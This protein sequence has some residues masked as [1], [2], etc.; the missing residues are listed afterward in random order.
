MTADEWRYHA[1]LSCRIQLSPVFVPRAR[2]EPQQQR[3]QEE[4]GTFQIH[5]FPMSKITLWAAF[6]ESDSITTRTSKEI[7]GNRID[8]NFLFQCSSCFIC[9]WSQPHLSSSLRSLLN[10]DR[11]FVRKRQWALEGSCIYLSQFRHGVNQNSARSNFTYDW[12]NAYY[13]FWL[14][15]WIWGRSSCYFIL[16]RG[17]THLF[18]DLTI[19]VPMIGCAGEVKS[20]LGSQQDH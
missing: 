12:G 13:S 2:Q 15:R 9:S 5:P 18:L 7:C 19:S 16:F 17:I 14:K 3:Q 6:I 4:K 11:N 1:I 20:Q 8:R 10:K